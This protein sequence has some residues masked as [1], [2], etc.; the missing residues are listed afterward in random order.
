MIAGHPFAGVLHPPTMLPPAN[1]TD[2][3]DVVNALPSSL[4]PLPS[5]TAS[6]ATT[7]PANVAPLTVAA[8]FTCQN[9]LQGEAPASSDMLE[10]TLAVTELPT[11][12][13]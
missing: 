6:C 10:P 9:T 13:M 1:V 8:L 5:V 3:S 12:K 11:L 4:P 7:V 2:P